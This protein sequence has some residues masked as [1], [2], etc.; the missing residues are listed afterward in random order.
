MKR[1][2]AVIV[3]AELFGTSLWFSLNGAATDLTRAWGLTPAQLGLLGMA[4]QAGFIVGTLGLVLSGIADR[5]RASRIFLVASLAGACCNAGFALFSRGVADAM[6]F[7]FATGVC[8]AGVYPLGMKLVFSWDPKRAASVLGWLVGTLT[9]GTA[10]PHLVRAA[11][12]SWHWQSVVITCSLLAVLGGACVAAV[13]DGP[14][15]PGASPVSALQGL[16][17]FRRPAYRASALGYFGHMWELY[18]FWT[19]VP[20]LVAALDPSSTPTAVALGSFFV[21]AAGA[22]GCVAGGS[23]A[24]HWGS[25]RVAAAALALSG[26]V[27]L[28]YPL[29]AGGASVVGY[30]LLLVWGWSVVAD[31]PQFSALSARACP[32]EQVGSGLAIQNCIGFLITLVSIQLATALWPHL[33]ARV[34]WVLLPGPVLGL[35]GMSLSRERR[36]R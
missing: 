9:L 30:A 27:C 17:V 13:G 2:V 16:S 35:A 1:P 32:P 29:A 14:H 33:G 12:A 7:R 23:L 5:F 6:V 18:A 28:V 3:L 21:I 10:T 19:V 36:E 8:L 22:V 11:G 4:V 31:S 20:L 24:E 25:T 34:A 26:A 15:L